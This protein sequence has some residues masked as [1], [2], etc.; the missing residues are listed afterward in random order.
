VQKLQYF[1]NRDLDLERRDRYSL[2]VIC[3]FSLVKWLMLCTGCIK[4]WGLN[5]LTL[6][7]L[8]WFFFHGLLLMRD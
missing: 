2:L 5:L 3:Y 8:C 6:E 1:F 4:Q 7:Y